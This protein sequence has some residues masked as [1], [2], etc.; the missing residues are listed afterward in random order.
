MKRTAKGPDGVAL[1]PYRDDM[2]LTM[3]KV[4]NRRGKRASKPSAPE[5]AHNS[6]APDP[7]QANPVDDDDDRSE[8]VRET[9]EEPV[10]D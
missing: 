10:K 9:L 3:K 7:D 8:D 1:R 2:A 6:L 4:L 5:D